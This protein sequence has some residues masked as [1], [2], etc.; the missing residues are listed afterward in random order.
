MVAMP[1][2]RRIPSCC[3]TSSKKPAARRPRILPGN[4][5][6]C[7][8]VGQHTASGIALIGVAPTGPVENFTPVKNRPLTTR[9]SDAARPARRAS[10]RRSQDNQRHS[11]H[12]ALGRAL[13]G[14]SSRLRP[15]HDGLQPLQ[16]LEPPR[17]LDRHLLRADRLDRHGRNHV[18]RLNA[19][20]SPSLCRWRKR[21][22]STTRSVA[23]AV[24]ARPKS[25]R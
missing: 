5:I 11:A 16:S 23:R 8:E 1:T 24:G 9:S 25:T 13:A 18:D 14:L 7:A 12:V 19:Y 4:G 15:L 2:A 17:H 3:R 21:G 22:P 6:A 20:Q 10:R